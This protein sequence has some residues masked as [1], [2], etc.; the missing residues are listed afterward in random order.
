MDAVVAEA[1][2]KELEYEKGQP[3]HAEAIERLQEV[4]R[5]KD[6]II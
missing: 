4:V 5:E 6:G 3:D 2:E 1:R